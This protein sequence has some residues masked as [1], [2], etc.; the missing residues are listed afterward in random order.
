[1]KDYELTVILDPEIADENVPATLE[2]IH[3]TITSRGGEV[4]DTDHWGR[5]RLAY[6]IKRKLEGNYFLSRVRMD[7][8]SERDLERTLNIAE[9]VLRH[10]VIVAGS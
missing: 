4:V 9:D 6:P 5:K 1:M 2:R 3:N 10:M 8:A 7:P